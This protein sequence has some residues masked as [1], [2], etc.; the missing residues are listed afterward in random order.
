PTRDGDTRR[1][2]MRNPVPLRR[3]PHR[4]LARNR[5][6]KWRPGR[7]RHSGRCLP[8]PALSACAAREWS[9]NIPGE[10]KHQTS[11][12]SA[13][14]PRPRLELTVAGGHG[15]C[16]VASGRGGGGDDHRLV[17]RH[18]LRVPV[19]RRRAQ[20]ALPR[21]HVLLRRQAHAGGRG[22]V[23]AGPGPGP[24][25]RGGRPQRRQ[26]RG[27]DAVHAEEAPGPEGQEVGGRA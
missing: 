23:R 9:R 22:G 7:E 12:A 2:P 26:R 14:A 25:R 17:P 13:A 8:C 19:P 16:R 21:R 11:R 1:A 15:R 24:G 18:P 10:Y 20:A 27:R 5:S 6:H 3:E 4:E